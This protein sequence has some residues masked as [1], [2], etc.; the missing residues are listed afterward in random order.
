MTT[1]RKKA[2]EVTP[3]PGATTLA[4][5]AGQSTPGT[6]GD[7]AP[8]ETVEEKQPVVPTLF[9]RKKDLNDRWV[10]ISQHDHIVNAPDGYKGPLT[11]IREEV[12]LEAMLER[13]SNLIER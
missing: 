5:G 2:T 3:A 12:V 4:T 11:G 9:F 13:G 8:A 1:R 7:V 10:I 6:D